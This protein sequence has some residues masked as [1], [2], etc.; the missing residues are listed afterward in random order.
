M[1]VIRTGTRVWPLCMSSVCGLLTLPVSIAMLMCLHHC[2]ALLCYTHDT[3]CYAMLIYGALLFRSYAFDTPGV[4]TVLDMGA[5]LFR[6]RFQQ[7]KEVKPYT[8]L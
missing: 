1:L 5:H 6:M 2:S 4:R 7:N 8:L 3:V